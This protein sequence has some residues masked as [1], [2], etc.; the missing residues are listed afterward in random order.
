MDKVN[1]EEDEELA[2]E[3]EGPSPSLHKEK[4][5]W[6]EIERMEEE[7][8]KLGD[9]FDEPEMEGLKPNFTL[10]DV[11]EVSEG[12]KS[13]ISDA[14]YLMESEG[15]VQSSQRVSDDDKPTSTMLRKQN[16]EPELADVSMQSFSKIDPA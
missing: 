12:E 15:A 5:Q 13:H 3:K 9:G 4:K 2:T 7:V 8:I 11:K 14:E 16:E 6:L 10:G 1:E